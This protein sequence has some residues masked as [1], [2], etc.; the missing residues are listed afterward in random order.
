MPP[1]LYGKQSILRGNVRNISALDALF[2][3]NVKKIRKKLGKNLVEPNKSST[4]ATANEKY[5]ISSKAFGVLTERLG[6]GLQNRVE[7]FDS[8]R[9]LFRKKG[10][11]FIWISFF[12]VYIPLTS[13]PT[14]PVCSTRPERACG[15]K[16]TQQ[17]VWQ[18]NNITRG[19][20]WINKI[21]S[22]KVSELT[23]F[24]KNDE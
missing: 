7:R 6:N 10:N 23:T 12:F 8:A 1:F 18:Q 21:I 2:T 4:F 3:R 13:E 14:N 19:I 9:H 17:G 16:M 24:K 11:S 20:W 22:N 15:N 5:N